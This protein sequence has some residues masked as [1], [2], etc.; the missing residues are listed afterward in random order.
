VGPSSLP[1]RQCGFSATTSFFVNGHIASNP[2]ERFNF[3]LPF[4]K[5]QHFPALEAM[6]MTITEKLQLAGLALG[7]TA[8]IAWIAF[9]GFALS[10]A[11]AWLL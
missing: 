7:M 11:V 1:Q 3:S 8:S 10:Q 9:L 4:K 2:N 6:S 5:T